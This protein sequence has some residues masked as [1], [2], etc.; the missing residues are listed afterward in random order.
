[1]VT[2][3]YLAIENIPSLKAIFPAFSIYVTVM[4]VIGI[5]L[6]VL[7]GYLHFRRVPAYSSESDISI[8]SNPFIYK[9]Y[10][11]WQTE[12]IFPFY[13]LMGNMMSKISNGE[14]LNDEE[15]KELEEIQNKIRVLLKGGYVGDDI[16]S[17]ILKPDKSKENKPN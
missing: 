4:L 6:L 14:K 13:L 8:T 2:T 1:M 10:P 17:S 7:I 11:G 9:A 16:P 3:Y 12:V 5:P 15:L